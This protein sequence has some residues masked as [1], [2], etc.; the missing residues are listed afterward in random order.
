MLESFAIYLDPASGSV[1][2]QIVIA[3]L[4][5]VA[6]SFKVFWT[7]IKLKLSRKEF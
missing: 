5:G 7:K 6:I 1:I 3:A 2:I 4:A